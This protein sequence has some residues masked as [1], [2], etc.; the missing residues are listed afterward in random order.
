VD[1]LKI[2]GSFVRHIATDAVDYALVGNINDIGHLLNK[3]TIAEF[4]EDAP[5]IARLRELRVDF[6]QGYGLHRP[7]PLADVLAA[8]ADA[9][10]ERH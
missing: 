9:G 6:A 10:T 5:T 8:S 2:D 4:A 1:Y 3:Q 7:Q